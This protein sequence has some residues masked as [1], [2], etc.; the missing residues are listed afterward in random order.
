[1]SILAQVRVVQFHVRYCLTS[2]P[3]RHS[4]AMTQRWPDWS[5]SESDK[6]YTAT[7]KSR[8]PEAPLSQEQALWKVVSRIAPSFRWLKTDLFML[9]ASTEN[10]PIIAK[11]AELLAMLGQKLLPNVGA[12]PMKSLE[13][14][15]PEVIELSS[16]L[17]FLAA[18]VSARLDSTSK[19]RTEMTDPWQLHDP[20]SNGGSAPCCDK[21]KGTLTAK[22]KTAQKSEENI[23]EVPA[24]TF[25]RFGSGKGKG[26]NKDDKSTTK[27]KV[28]GTTQ[29]FEKNVQEAAVDTEVQ[30][31][32]NITE[33]REMQ[34]DEMTQVADASSQWEAG[35]LTEFDQM[36]TDSVK[37]LDHNLG[38]AGSPMGRNE[39]EAKAKHMLQAGATVASLKTTCKTHN[40]RL[41]LV[42]Q[43]DV[44]RKQCGNAWL[45][46]GNN[47]LRFSSESN[48]IVVTQVF[49]GGGRVA[50]RCSRNHKY[51]D[52]DLVEHLFEIKHENA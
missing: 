1:M 17:A 43:G 21:S 38:Y 28:P 31:V 18:P 5:G 12:V 15:R 22:D 19:T 40:V 47:G 11:F 14:A 34:T 6:T 13:A 8:K 24:L 41:D 30:T 9:A 46:A 52:I 25:N 51:G 50:A 4:V 23:V 32:N 45:M 35:M 10:E 42:R 39:L 20:W 33:D 36:V 2:Y 29:A 27:S 7:A 26:K 44:L 16:L 3:Q 49:D 48:E 37:I